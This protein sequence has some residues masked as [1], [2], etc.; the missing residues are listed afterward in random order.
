MLPMSRKKYV[1][2]ASLL[3]QPMRGGELGEKRVTLGPPL[4]DKVTTKYE[5]I[6]L[7][8][9]VEPEIYVHILP[10]EEG[11]TSLLSVRELLKSLNRQW[12]LL[13]IS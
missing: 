3:K 12:Y 9:C 2:Q 13:L 8:G 11:T 5:V 7:K 10:H 4:S 1:M 6:P